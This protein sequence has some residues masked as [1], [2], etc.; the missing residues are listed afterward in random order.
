MC[1]VSQNNVPW[2]YPGNLSLLNRKTYNILPE[3]TKLHS[4]RP[5]VGNDA[6]P[7]RKRPHPRLYRKAGSTGNETTAGSENPTYK[8]IFVV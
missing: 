7:R 6:H 5:R 8:V 4:K 3:V 1:P 2:P